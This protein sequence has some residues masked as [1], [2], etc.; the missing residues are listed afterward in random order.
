MV[1]NL[2]GGGVK[3]VAP[4]EIQRTVY[5]YLTG[6]GG[7]PEGGNVGWVPTGGALQMQDINIGQTVSFQI[8]GQSGMLSN[9]CPNMLQ[10]LWD[11]QPA[12]AATNVLPGVAKKPL[13]RSK[14]A[15]AAP[16]D[17]AQQAMQTLNAQW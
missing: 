13:K 7:Y 11:N 9:A 3:D 2:R 12:V 14:L 15:A 8:N 10:L 5:C 17:P 4:N 16:T 1:Q 6:Q